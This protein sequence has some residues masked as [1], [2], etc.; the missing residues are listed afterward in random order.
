MKTI[1]CHC[2]QC[3][4]AK[5][6]IRKRNRVQT[7]QVRSARH[8]TKRLIRENLKNNELE[9]DNLEKIVSVDYYA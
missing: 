8:K 9:M 1:I 2:S 3:R 4:A 6:G 7:K 5:K